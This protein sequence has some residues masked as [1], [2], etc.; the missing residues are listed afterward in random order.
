MENVEERYEA[1]TERNYQA[2]LAEEERRQ[3]LIDQIV[4]DET[5][6]TRL[7]YAYANSHLE[8]VPEVSFLTYAVEVRRRELEPEYKNGWQ[9]DV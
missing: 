1:I 5:L 4:V 6:F 2:V 9:E 3:D 8:T 7:A